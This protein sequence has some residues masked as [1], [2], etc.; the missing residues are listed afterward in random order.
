MSAIVLYPINVGNLSFS[1]FPYTFFGDFTY[2]SSFQGTEHEQFNATQLHTG[3]FYQ[4]R[5]DHLQIDIVHINTL[6]VTIFA[7]LRRDR[8]SHSDCP[9]SPVTY[10]PSA[11]KAVGEA[12]RRKSSSHRSDANASSDLGVRM[13]S[14]SSSG[15]P[16]VP[17]YPEEEML[18]RRRSSL[19]RSSMHRSPSTSSYSPNPHYEVPLLEKSGSNQLA[20]KRIVFVNSIDSDMLIRTCRRELS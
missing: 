10:N 13:R 9:R 4:V 12:S 5:T 14:R 18:D 6:I 2:V 1:Y 20:R 7:G 16:Q 17:D 8:T 19:S 3:S 11:E 15:T